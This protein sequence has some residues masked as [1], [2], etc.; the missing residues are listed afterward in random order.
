VARITIQDA[1]AWAEQTKMVSAT[2]AL[3]TNLLGQIEEEVLAQISTA[4]TTT[5]WTSDANTPALVKTI[6]A[7]MYI[8]WLIDKHYSED[9]DLNAYAGRL[10]A[11]A[12]ALLNG[13]VSGDIEIPG[14]DNTL[15]SGQPSFYPN[16]ASSASVAT[17]ADP[18]LGPA[19]FSMGVVF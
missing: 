19:K 6:I 2:A 5:S 10:A 15:G 14:V 17:A 11:G 16:D 9:E 1:Q 8:S 3:D 12:S 13:I 4:V 18:S 7:R